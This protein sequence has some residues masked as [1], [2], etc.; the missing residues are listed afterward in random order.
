MGKLRHIAIAVPDADE[1]AKFYEQAFGMKRVRESV[2]AVMLTDGV[3]SLAILNNQTSHEALGHSGLHHVGFITENVDEAAMQAE[4]SGAV[5]ADKAENVAKRF[6]NR[7]QLE[8]GK[9]IAAAREQEQRK[10]VDPNGVKFDIVNDAHARNS[11]R[12]PV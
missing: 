2:T 7:G 3:V 6:A 11:W 1:T 4:K 9:V 12:L 8:D 5:Y 10:Y